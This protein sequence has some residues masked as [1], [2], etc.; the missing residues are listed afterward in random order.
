[1]YDVRAGLEYAGDPRQEYGVSTDRD[2]N[3]GGEFIR[4]LEDR[5]NGCK[6]GGCNCLG[7]LG[8][9]VDDQWDAVYVTGNRKAGLHIAQN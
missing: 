5:I 4:V 8:L 9:E 3:T 1:V 2:L 7:T 6:I